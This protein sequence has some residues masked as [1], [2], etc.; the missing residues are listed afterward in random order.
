M[1][2]W[3]IDQWRAAYRKKNVTPV[4]AMKA[5][6]AQLQDSERALWIHLLDEASLLAQ[7][8]RLSDSSLPLYGVPFAIKDN[9]DV[10]SLPSTAACPAYTYTAKGTESPPVC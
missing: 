5:H 2:G 1:L 3:T 4:S 6:S 8:E 9:I 10:G 7:A